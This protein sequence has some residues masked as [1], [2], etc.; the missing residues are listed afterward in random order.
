M[1][2]RFVMR[3][4]PYDLTGSWSCLRMRQV[5]GSCPVAGVILS[6]IQYFFCV[7]TSRGNLSFLHFLCKVLY[8]SHHI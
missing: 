5:G 2:Y 6:D 8:F 7:K 1:P 3:H 4:C